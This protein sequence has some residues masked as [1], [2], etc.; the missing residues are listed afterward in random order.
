MT[1]PT[2]LRQRVPRDG[3]LGVDDDG[4]CVSP[5]FKLEGGADDEQ[6]LADLSAD[7]TWRLLKEDSVTRREMSEEAMVAVVRRLLA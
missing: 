7:L 1:E 5:K 6:V 2:W 3:I 4:V